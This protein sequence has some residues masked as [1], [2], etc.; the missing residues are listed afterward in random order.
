MESEKK[1]KEELTLFEAQRRLKAKKE[2][3]GAKGEKKSVTK[4]EAPGKEK[5]L[6]LT[7]GQVTSGKGVENEDFFLQHARLSR[8]AVALRLL[9]FH[10]QQRRRVQ[11]M[12]RLN[13]AWRVADGHI[14]GALSPTRFHDAAMMLANANADASEGVKPSK[15]ET[16]RAWASA[17]QRHDELAGVNDVMEF[18]SFCAAIDSLGL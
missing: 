2:K 11:R 8:I 10:L 9:P 17:L 6:S 18:S 1:E 4:E 14:A 15:E 3:L 12:V 16:A 5:P 7:P 13:E